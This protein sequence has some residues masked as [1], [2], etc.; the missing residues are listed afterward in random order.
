V[1]LLEVLLQVLLLLLLGVGGGAGAGGVGC[2]GDAAGGG[3]AAGGG[4][5]GWQRSQCIG[6]GLHFYYVSSTALYE[7]GWTADRNV[8]L[9]LCYI[10]QRVTQYILSTENGALPVA[11]WSYISYYYSIQHL[12]VKHIARKSTYIIYTKYTYTSM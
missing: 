8:A 4:V 11:L 10:R 2:V 7:H 5:G 12:P 6:S 1:V 9:V 3:S